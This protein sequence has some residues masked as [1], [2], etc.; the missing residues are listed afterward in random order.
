MSDQYDIADMLD[1]GDLEE[2]HFEHLSKE[3]ESFSSWDD[4]TVF[5]YGLTMGF[6][7]QSVYCS[8]KEMDIRKAMPHL[9]PLYAVYQD[10]RDIPTK[11]Y[12]IEVLR[13]AASYGF[14]GMTSL[15]TEKRTPLDDNYTTLKKKSNGA[16]AHVFG[17]ID[18]KFVE[19]DWTMAEDGLLTRTFYRR[20][21]LPADW[22]FL[23]KAPNAM[24]DLLTAMLDYPKGVSAF[25]CTLKD[26]SHWTGISREKPT[27]WATDT[28]ITV[29]NKKNSLLMN[30][31]R[32]D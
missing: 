24:Y 3:F 32:E 11:Q 10:I 30:A 13:R 5:F 12:I 19:E 23:K 26:G 25:P 28:E 14:L 22:T 15:D 31:F 20:K 9:Q 17:R 16:V 29:T 6:E 27:P 18:D 1:M 21:V 2:K 4:E 8:S 7:G